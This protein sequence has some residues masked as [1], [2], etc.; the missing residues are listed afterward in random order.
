MTGELWTREFQAVTVTVN[1]TPPSLQ[2][3]FEWCYGNI[4]NKT[5]TATTTTMATVV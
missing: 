5:T 3:R 4:T 1:C 2:P